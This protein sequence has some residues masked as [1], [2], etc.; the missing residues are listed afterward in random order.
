MV[1]TEQSDEKA[2]PKR[3]LF[4][5][6]EVGVILSIQ[7]VY[8]FHRFV[9]YNFLAEADEETKIIH[10]ISTN[11]IYSSM[12]ILTFLIFRFLKKRSKTKSLMYIEYIVSSGFILS[13]ILFI[14]YYPSTTIPI[15]IDL[16]FVGIDAIF[17]MEIG[18]GFY[19]LHGLIIE[20]KDI[21]INKKVLNTFL[22]V[23]GLVS[24]LF[25]N[26]FNYKVYLLYLTVMIGFIGVLLKKE[27]RTPAF[28]KQVVIPSFS[29]SKPHPFVFFFSILLTFA[30]WYIAYIYLAGVFELVDDYQNREFT[31]MYIAW[32]LA[33]CMGFLIYFKLVKTRKNPQDKEKAWKLLEISFIFMVLLLCIVFWLPNIT[34]YNYWQYYLVSALIMVTPGFSLAKAFELLPN[35]K[36]WS[37]VLSIVLF[38]LVTYMA[39]ESNF[40]DYYY[41]S[42]NYMTLQEQIVGLLEGFLFIPLVL[43]IMWI[44]REIVHH[45]K[46]R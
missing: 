22:T 40:L 38:F 46:K 33:M 2:I 18:I 20:N 45:I 32:T 43:L 13:C 34:I 7:I 5:N 21:P 3:Q 11:Y 27:L 16:L 28:E 9:M 26:I 24:G 8:F 12:A 25:F 36:V 41:T 15:E 4:I 39:P 42:Y 37:Y 1:F 30:T 31:L 23:L 14:L 29:P 35:L 44:L 17:G 10:Q 6:F 19:M